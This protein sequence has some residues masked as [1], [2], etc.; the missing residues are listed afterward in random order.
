[1]KKFIQIFAG[2]KICR[3]QH[4][5]RSARSTQQIIKI[6]GS[7]SKWHSY[8]ILGCVAF[9]YDYTVVFWSVRAGF[10]IL[11]TKLASIT[12]LSL[13]WWHIDQY[14]DT[15]YGHQ[16]VILPFSRE[17]CPEGPTGLA[18]TFYCSHCK[19]SFPGSNAGA[20]LRI[21]DTESIWSCH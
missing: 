7:D 12:R 8:P 5:V 3:N 10:L 13:W 19:P 14:F 18:T 11:S 16:W 9:S 15:A 21:Y 2:T 17:R 6:H 4:L 20:R 1:M